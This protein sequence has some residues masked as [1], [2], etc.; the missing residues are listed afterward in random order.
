MVVGS[1]LP[2]SSNSICFLSDL[3]PVRLP[4]ASD[5]LWTVQDP[6]PSPFRPRWTGCF[7]SRE[8]RPPCALFGA[9]QRDP[10]LP[11]EQS[12][13]CLCPIRLPLAS[14][15]L[16]A[17]QDPPRRAGCFRPRK[18]GLR[19]P[20]AAHLSE[21]RDSLLGNAG[22][23]AFAGPGGGLKCL[24]EEGT[25]FSQHSRCDSDSPQCEKRWSLCLQAKGPHKQR[26]RCASDSPS[27]EE[28]WSLCLQVEGPH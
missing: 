2:L 7:R 23:L 1:S 4:L 18:F 17:I 28:R 27:C 24:Q 6:P 14:D 26:S 25:H 11:R 9:P 8:V 3:C 15:E 13:C 16:W 5:E 21:T 22:V 12:R 20:S 10:R 19:A